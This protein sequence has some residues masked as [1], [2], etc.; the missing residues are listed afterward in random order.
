[1]RSIDDIKANLPV[2]SVGLQHGF[3]VEGGF[4]ISQKKLEWNSQYA[5]VNGKQGATNSY[6]TGFSYYPRSAQHLKLSMDTTY[7]DGSPVDSTGSDI[8]V[9]DSGVLVR[10]QFQVVF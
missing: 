2:P 8:F 1:L 7:I 9:G 5:F 6:A 3:Y 4:F 10:T